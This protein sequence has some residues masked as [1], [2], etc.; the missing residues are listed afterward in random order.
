MIFKRYGIDIMISRHDTIK[1]TL[2]WILFVAQFS[3]YSAAS[4]EVGNCATASANDLKTWALASTK[5]DCVATPESILKGEKFAKAFQGKFCSRY[6]TPTPAYPYIKGW[7]WNSQALKQTDPDRAAFE[8]AHQSINKTCRRIAWA[9]D[10]A[11]AKT[12]CNKCVTDKENACI[13]SSKVK[14][15]PK[16]HD[17]NHPEDVKV[18]NKAIKA[19]CR[20]GTF[21]RNPRNGAIPGIGTCATECNRVK[22]LVAEMD[23]VDFLEGIALPSASEGAGAGE[24]GSGS[25]NEGGER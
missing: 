12:K 4:E 25:D 19:A 5:L 10:L 7:Q 11:D 23:Q 15:D 18:K 9:F 8:E 1:H 22:G 21:S 16:N 13:N 24:E 14:I 6:K 20:K 17:E 2:F 3:L